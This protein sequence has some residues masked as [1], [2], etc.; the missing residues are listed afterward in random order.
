[1]SANFRHNLSMFGVNMSWNPAN[2]NVS[3]CF[4]NW[5]VDSLLKHFPANVH[6]NQT[7]CNLIT[8][9][10]HRERVCGGRYS[11][12]DANVTQYRQSFK[13]YLRGSWFPKITSLHASN[14][15]FFCLN[16]YISENWYSL[17]QR[18][19][20]LKIIIEQ[21]VLYIN[22]LFRLQIIQFATICSSCLYIVFFVS[23][24]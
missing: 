4:W 13:K 5:K 10:T 23:M 6:Q 18:L 20:I 11:I 24:T 7:L 9:P 19:F 16:F 12:W 3:P 15:Q 14:K 21:S 1:M 17:H 8:F 2:V 22:Q